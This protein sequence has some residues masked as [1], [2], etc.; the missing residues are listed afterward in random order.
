MLPATNPTREK[1]G[2]V[3]G[4]AKQD[5]PVVTPRWFRTPRREEWGIPAAPFWPWQLR[6]ELYGPQRPQDHAVWYIT[7]ALGVFVTLA[8]F[9]AALAMVPA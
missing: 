1:P 6:A 3:P 5:S 2:T 8:V 4:T 9:G 7:A